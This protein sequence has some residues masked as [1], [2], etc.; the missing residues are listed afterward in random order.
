MRTDVHN[1]VLPRAAIDLFARDP[2]YRV[3]IRGRAG[4]EATI[5][6]S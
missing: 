2:V 3:E 4:A 6:R 5:R 1:H